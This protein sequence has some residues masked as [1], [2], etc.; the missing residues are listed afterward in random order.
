MGFFDDIADGFRSLTGG[1][2]PDL[3]AA[4][5]MNLLDNSARHQASQVSIIVSR[6]HDIVIR[7][8]DNGSGILEDKRLHIQQALDAQDYTER[9]GL[10][11]MLCDMVARAHGGRLQLSTENQGCAVELHF[12]TLPPP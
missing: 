2:D 8:R 12:A 10:G 5:L 11:L 3:L 4:A 9:T 1:A 6:G 7:V